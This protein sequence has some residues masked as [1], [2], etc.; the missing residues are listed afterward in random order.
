MIVEQPSLF[1]R[2]LRPP[3]PSNHLKN[4]ICS[5][6]E[7]LLTFRGRQ[8]TET[9]SA[10]ASFHPLNYLQGLKKRRRLRGPPTLPQ[11]RKKISEQH[12]NSWAPTLSTGTLLSRPRTP[13]QKQ[14]L[15]SLVAANGRERGF[16]RREWE[17][18]PPL[19][20][21]LG[22]APKPNSGARRTSPE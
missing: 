14:P 9:A 18:F 21:S 20:G 19:S 3:F 6:L 11:D 17:K 1:T 12:P 16:P 2:R 7:R 15:L 13:Q 5:H 22:E 8:C 4:K 10:W